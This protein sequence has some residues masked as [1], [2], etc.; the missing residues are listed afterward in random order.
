M[1]RFVLVVVVAGL[2]G[3]SRVSVGLHNGTGRTILESGVTWSNTER[4]DGADGPLSAGMVATCAT[5]PWPVPDEVRVTWISDNGSEH[6]KNISTKRF[7]RM[8]FL[9]F[10]IRPDGE[11]RV[12][13][14]P[15]GAEVTEMRLAEA[16]RTEMSR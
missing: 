11:V 10:S 14:L 13:N 3:C 8:E 2:V 9:V 7:D 5:A 4:L 12:A 6:G 16:W 15:R 1:W